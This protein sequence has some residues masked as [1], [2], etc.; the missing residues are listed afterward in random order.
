MP[1]IPT[2]VK[3]GSDFPWWPASAARER[4]AGACS[5]PGRALAAGGLP[6]DQLIPCARR[7]ICWMAQVSPSLD[8]TGTET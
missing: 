8:A 5:A 7:M 2:A 4:A 1:C 6:H 3:P